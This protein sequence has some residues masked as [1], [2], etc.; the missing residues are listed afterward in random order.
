MAHVLIDHFIVP[1]AARAA[2]DERRRLSEA[3]VKAQPGFIEGFVYELVGAGPYT[4][5]TTAVWESAEHFAAARRAAAA[6]YERM[7][8]DMQLFLETNGITLSRGEYTRLPY[9]APASTPGRT[10]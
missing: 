8:I 5:I 3:I 1:A 10:S 6:E 7:G 2:F 4:H 9:G